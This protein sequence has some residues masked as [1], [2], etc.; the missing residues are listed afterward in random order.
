[1]AAGDRGGAVIVMPSN[2]TG[3]WCGYLAH[4]YEG[5]PVGLGHLFSPGFQLKRGPVMRYALD[6][7]AFG[8]WKNGTRFDVAAWR[9]LLEWAHCADPAPL[10]CLVPDVVG[11]R[12][13]TLRNWDAYAP[14][15]QR[16]G[17]PLAFAAQDGMTFADVPTEAAIV[18]IGGSDEFK[19]EALFPW[20]ARFPCHVGRVTALDHLRLVLRAGAKSCDAT[21]YFRTDRQR[22]DLETFLAEANGESL[23]QSSG[24]SGAATVRGSKSCATTTGGVTGAGRCGS[25][26]QARRRI[27]AADPV[28]AQSSLFT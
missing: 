21:G 6:N 19:A 5:K 20:C 9:K 7:G 18:F 4:K 23:S 28:G 15:V 25:T 26:R 22:H 1:M 3:F 11:D 17:W 14:E 8:C 2:V 27:A 16:M 24:L 13:A 12:D 10:W